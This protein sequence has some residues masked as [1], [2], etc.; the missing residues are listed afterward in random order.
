MA[1]NLLLKLSLQLSWIFVSL[2]P[3]WVAGTESREPYAVS[4]GLRQ[5]GAEIRSTAG[6]GTRALRYE[7]PGSQSGILTIRPKCSPL[8]LSL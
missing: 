3:T 8:Q 6:P 2:S 5:Q 7:M 4:Q 1:F